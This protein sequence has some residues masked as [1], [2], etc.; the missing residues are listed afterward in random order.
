MTL[1]RSDQLFSG[2]ASIAALLTTLIFFVTGG[3]TALAAL[4]SLA[5]ILFYCTPLAQR[6]S[7]MGVIACLLFVFL[8]LDIPANRPFVEFDPLT[9]HLGY[10]L[11]EAGSKLFGIPGLRLIGLEIITFAMVL[12]LA[13]RNRRREWYNLVFSPTF[14]FALLLAALIPATGLAFTAFGVVKGNSLALAITQIRFMPMMA[15][16]IYIGYVACRSYA[17]TVL[18]MRVFVA[19]MMIKALQGWFAYFIMF[20][21]EMGD[22]EY[23]LEHLQS[24]YMATAIFILVAYFF[25]KERRTP[26]WAIVLAGI[27]IFVPY[28]LN[29]RRA[30]FLGVAFSIILSPFVLKRFIQPRHIILATCGVLC[31]G[32]FIVGTWNMTGPVGFLSQ[33]IKSVFLRGTDADVQ[34]PDYR[35]LENYNLYNAAAQNPI[36]GLGFGKRF[37]LVADMP[38]ISGIYESYDLIPHNN[39]LFMWAY[40]GAFGMA[41][42]GT[43][44]AFALAIMIRLHRLANDWRV[45]AFAF[46]G[47]T[48]IIRWSIYVYADI[49]LLEAR[50]TSIVGLMVGAGISLLS[51]LEIAS[52]EV[53]A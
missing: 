45:L 32:A 52:K 48:Q 13:F 34:E 50:T 9:E 5:L 16:W 53:R 14:Q 28:I 29:D 25:A 36:T 2:L 31:T 18:I 20:G 33:T 38:N 21:G 6:M 41:A 40:G 44:I 12:W 4:P 42:L 26:A 49:G 10:L 22:R 19:A 17:D 43:F 46:L 23:I 30:S 35:D 1:S 39:A 51:H 15:C 47:F 27:T 3:N 11:F 37:E 7:D 8:V 24:D